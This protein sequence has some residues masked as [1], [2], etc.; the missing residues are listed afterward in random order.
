MRR[1]LPILLV[2]VLWCAPVLAGDGPPAPGKKDRCPVCGMFVAPY[3]N[4][5]AAA[6][7]KDGSYVHFDGPKDLFR[8]FF[9]VATYLPEKTRDDIRQLWVSEYY[10]TRPTRV[11]ELFFVS[12]SD[13][14]GPMGEELVPIAGKESAET[15]LRDHGGKKIL[16]FDG[17]DLVEVAA[18]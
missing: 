3:A 18:Q 16:R 12:G 8:F 17:H 11:E 1:V 14:L 13:V 7:L 6:E 5:H 9:A 2:L 10:S 4:W 15:F